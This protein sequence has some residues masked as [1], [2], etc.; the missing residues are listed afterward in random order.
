MGDRVAM[1][2]RAGGVVGWWTEPPGQPDRRVG[3]HLGGEPLG[4]QIPRRGQP[5][6]VTRTHTVTGEALGPRFTD[7][8]E[9]GV[10][11]VDPALR[12]STEHDVVGMV[13]RL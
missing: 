6:D 13:D 4:A 1:G 11:F 8:V 5:L 12:R 2:H 9:R 10:L 7:L 3:L